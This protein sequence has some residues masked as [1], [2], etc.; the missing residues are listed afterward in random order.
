MSSQSTLFSNEALPLAADMP[1]GFRY[2]PELISPEEEAILIR[3]IET[4][5]LK[6][7]QF[8]QFE[9]KRRVI[10]FGFRY[11]YTQRSVQ[12]AD[13][14]AE[15]LTGLRGKVA[16]FA[17]RPAGDFRQVLVTEYTPGT[18]IGWHR[19]K[20]Q[21][22]EIVG[23]SLLSPANFRLRRRDGD[24][25]LRKSKRLEPRS[26][27][28]LRGEVRHRWEHSI[29]EVDALRYSVTFRTLADHFKAPENEPRD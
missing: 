20:S 26:A 14:I 24:R 21:F 27:Y 6:P 13:S 1:E 22:G 16:A 10:S 19:D 25:W 23:V 4:L 29:P 3:W 7:F 12:L 2:V 28:I 11:D 9:G 17:E 15:A 18:P 5:P 8:G